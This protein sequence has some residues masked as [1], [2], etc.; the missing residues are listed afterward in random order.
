MII[1][2]IRKKEIDLVVMSAHHRSRMNEFLL[3]SV[4]ARVAER[5]GCSVMLL[6]N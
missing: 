5:A 2:Y 4:S 3:G 1:R 6:K